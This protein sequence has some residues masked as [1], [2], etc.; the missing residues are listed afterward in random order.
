M[1]QAEHQVEQMTME[2]GTAFLDS[3][4]WEKLSPQERAEFQLLQDRLWMPFSVFQDAV[5]T[6]L[7]R[8]V[9]TPELGFNRQGLI[10]ELLQG[11]PTPTLQNILDKVR[12]DQPGQTSEPTDS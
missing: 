5:A 8:P 12:G 3:R 6:A 2:Q 11:N 10:R 4:A 7:E 9:D 1:Q